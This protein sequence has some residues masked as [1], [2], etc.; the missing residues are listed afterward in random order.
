MSETL[1]K[2]CLSFTLT[3]KLQYDLTQAWNC[4]FSVKAIERRHKVMK[5]HVFLSFECFVTPHCLYFLPL[6]L[7]LN[8]SLSQCLFHYKLALPYFASH[9]LLYVCNSLDILLPICIPPSNIAAS[10][11]PLMYLIPSSPSFCLH[12]CLWPD[13]HSCLWPS[14]CLCAAVGFLDAHQ[15]G[16]VITRA[17]PKD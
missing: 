2:W 6:T 14:S 11:Y 5:L 13:R 12:H 9:M 17:E 16:G 4:W 3:I 15:E 10:P 1:H 7:S 8:S